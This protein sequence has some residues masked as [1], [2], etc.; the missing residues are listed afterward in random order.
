MELEL[1]ER[2]VEGFNEEQK[3][4]VVKDHNTIGY[5]RTGLL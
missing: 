3:K 4:E 5:K 1:S 2:E